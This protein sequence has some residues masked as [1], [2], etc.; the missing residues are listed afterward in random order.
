MWY[1]GIDWADTHHE[2]VVIDE[3]GGR[4]AACRV[5]HTPE[6]LAQ[7]VTFL[8]ATVASAPT[9]QELACLI[10]TTQGLLITALLDAGL[11]I[12][13][14]NPK[15]VDRRRKPSGAKT[16]AIDAYLLAKTGRSDL[17]S[18]SEVTQIR[19]LDGGTG[20]PSFSG[21]SRPASPSGSGWRSSPGSSTSK[22]AEHSRRADP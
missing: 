5:A 14:V 22:R 16:D 8:Q 1:A 19:P 20:A 9:P 10:E 3:Q 11:T 15:T 7:L 13:P 21:L 4:V 6:G 12:Y 18:A 2:A 17:A